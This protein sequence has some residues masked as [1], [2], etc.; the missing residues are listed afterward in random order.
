M[1]LT[2]KEKAKE[3]VDEYFELLFP[4]IENISCR[5]IAA[6]QCAI[7]NVNEMLKDELGVMPAKWMSDYWEVVKQEIEKI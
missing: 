1:G 2:P 3:L 4:F 6:K 7:H 5:L